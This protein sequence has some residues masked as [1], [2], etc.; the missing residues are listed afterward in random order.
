[1][2]QIQSFDVIIV[3]AGASGLM[4]AIECGKRGRTV[5]V[6]EKSKKPGRKILM[7]GGGFCNFTNYHVEPSCFLSHNPHFYKSALKQYTQWDFIELV[8]KHRIQ[9]HEKTKG[10]LFCNTKNGQILK[11]L[12]DECQ[13][14]AIRMQ[15]G[16]QIDSVKKTSDA[17]YQLATASGTYTCQ[18]LVVATGGLSIPSMGSSAWGYQLAEQFGLNVK[19]L[20]AGLVPL[21]LHQDDKAQLSQLSGISFESNVHYQQQSFHENTL[22]THRGIS[23]P[24]ILQISSYWQAGHDI[25]INCLPH[26]DIADALKDH[27]SSQSVKTYLAQFLPKRFLDTQIDAH[28][29]KK[30]LCHLQKKDLTVLERI[31]HHWTLKPN[32]TEGYRTAEV[33]L[34]G[35]DCNDL[36]SKTM[37]TYAHKGLYFIGEV[38]DVTGWLGGYN[39]QWAW[40]SG[41]VAGQ[42]A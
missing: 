10:Q 29:L 31:L 9:F 2:Q 39:F 32:G 25:T 26:I 8:K 40:S 14:K 42:F 22:I 15:Y 41:F 7:A 28:L 13:D 30:P 17:T 1:M 11:L 19:P 6:I 5:L 4:A 37:E 38:V 34:G 27:R 23:G 24:A 3:G 18:S 16:I 21:T 36:S 20:R 33:T 35:V 12:L